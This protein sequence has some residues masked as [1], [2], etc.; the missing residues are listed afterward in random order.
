MLKFGHLFFLL[1]ALGFVGFFRGD[2]AQRYQCCEINTKK[3]K[4][5]DFEVCGFRLDTTG[6]EIR[7]VKGL[8]TA[9]KRP[10]GADEKS[11]NRTRTLVYV[12]R[13][14]LDFID[15]TYQIDAQD[16]LCAVS[17]WK[18]SSRSLKIKAQRGQIFSREFA[19]VLGKPDRVDKKGTDAW[20][21][22][23]GSR[24]CLQVR[25]GAFYCFRVSRTKI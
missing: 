12:V 13:Q 18:M 25:A 22:Y 23:H 17:G 21:Y 14:G 24:L 9:V 2:A 10:P 8:P 4:D 5:F 7:K 16:R 11:Q 19:L 1:V 15:E 6:D 3:M 20:Y